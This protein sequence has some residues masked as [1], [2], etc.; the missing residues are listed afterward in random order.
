MIPEREQIEHLYSAKE[1]E[2]LDRIRLATAELDDPVERGEM[3]R[4]LVRALWRDELELI[5]KTHWIATKADGL[6]LCT[7]NYAQKR[8]YKDVIQ[9]CRSENRPIRGII[10]K[11]RQ[12]GFSTF[13]QLWNYEQCDR[14]KYRFA[15]TI[16]YDEASTEELFQKAKM[17]RANQWFP[18]GSKRERR[19][20]MEF[21]APHGSIFYTR[22]AGNVS[23][24]RGITLHHLHCS[25]V[26]MWPDAERVLVSVHQGV[27]AHL[28]TSIIHESTAMGA[29]GVFYDMWNQAEAGENDFVPFFAPWFWDEEYQLPFANEDRKRAF[30]REMLPDDRDYMT[31]FK[32]SPEQM[33]WRD[34]KVRN[35][36]SGSLAQFQQEFPACAEEAFLTTGSPVFSPRA[37]R[38]LMDQC[39]APSWCGDVVMT[40]EGASPPP[41]QE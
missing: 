14:L 2:V 33:H 18:R 28:G 4:R 35:E 34:F 17:V 15:M 16:S 31:R 12:L 39:V 27:P 26:P 8:F 38:D 40:H 29:V 7:P 25:E 41:N 32:L 24:G 11:A 36:L 21:A 37:V 20:T 10:L 22:T 23:A 5:A 13:I 6:K 1:N 19:S 9:R 30:L 3:G